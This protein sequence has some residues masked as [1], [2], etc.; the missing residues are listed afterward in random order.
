VEL[1]D[2]RSESEMTIGDS[3][4]PT[5]GE[6]GEELASQKRRE[7]LSTRGD[8]RGGGVDESDETGMVEESSGKEVTGT[9][10][11]RGEGREATGGGGGAGGALEAVG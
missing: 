9:R 6:G 11:T 8:T 3:A 10:M 4:V 5:S 2:S 1:G 7:N